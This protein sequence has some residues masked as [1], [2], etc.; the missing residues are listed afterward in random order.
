[1]YTSAM[2]ANILAFEK[3]RKCWENVRKFGL[4]KINCYKFLE[5][6]QQITSLYGSQVG[7]PS[8]DSG[9]F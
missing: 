7:L 5:N 8:W 4:M 6:L 3:W 2:L 9:W 1:M